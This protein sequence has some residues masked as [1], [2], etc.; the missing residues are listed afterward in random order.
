MKN[1]IY[2]FFIIF[3]LFMVSSCEF[4]Q[5]ENPNAVTLS[6]SDITLILNRVQVNFA[7]FFN[8]SAYSGAAVTRI[9]HQGGDTY[10][11]SYPATALNCPW[12]AYSESL[13]DIRAIKELGDAGRFRRH[14]GMAKTM[15]AYILMTL[16][17]V[18]GDVP[19][20]K[21]FDNSNF[22]P[23]RDKG[24]DVYKAALDLLVSAQADYI[25]GNSVGTPNDLFFGAN[26]TK[27][28]KLNNAFQLKYWM[29]RR[30][31]DKAGATTAINA[32]IAKNA[33]PAPGDEFVW[34]YGTSLSDPGTRHPQYQP[35]GGGDYQSNFFMWHLTEA[36][37]FDDP[38]APYYFYRQ[39]IANPTNASEIRCL[40]EFLPAHYPQGAVFCLPGKRGYWGRDFMDPQGIP[41]DNLKRTLYGL[42]PVGGLFDNN[43]GVSITPTNPGS[44]G[45]GIEAIMLPAFV[46]F[47]L[48]EAALQLGTT[49]DPKALMIS[50]I[51]KHINY[52]RAFALSTDQAAK[53]TAFISNDAQAANLKKY[54][55]KAT[56]DF[57][58]L[59]T[60]ADKMRMIAREYWISL[61]GNG[62]EAYNLYRRT[63]QPDGMQLG[64]VANIGKF[65]R[66]FFYPAN[67]V[68]R[69]NQAPQKA[70]HDVKV[71]WD[72]NPDGFI[73]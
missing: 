5:L 7:G 32:L 48:A 24:E 34:R 16:V 43:V 22:N 70:S 71:F 12:S 49:G 30:L 3:G 42:Y 62:M 41:P 60:P 15:E 39:V 11:I 14:V 19:Y 27:W 35:Q 17:D 61:Y 59:A 2:R 29:N 9:Y 50:G 23:P 13:R 51:T 28:A 31:V 10:E 20:F 72:N 1:L 36:K 26:F 64:Q 38:R 68:E 67:H 65:P 55:D 44:T 53:V 45:A 40:G 4:D 46:D 25:D 52:V 54:T 18:Y 69:N 63:G 56:A 33:F 8:C 58:K 73:K 47:M 57:D 21:A 66:S 37:G 6:S